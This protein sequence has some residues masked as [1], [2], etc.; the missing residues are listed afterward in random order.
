MMSAP[1]RRHA[2]AILAS[3]VVA[4][5]STAAAQEPPLTREEMREFLLEADIIKSR[6]IPI[7][8]TRPERL[9]LRLGGLTHD[10]GFNYADERKSV[11]TFADGTREVDFVDSYHYNIA[12]YELAGLLGLEDMM[13]VTVERAWRGRNGSL[14]WWLPT[15]MTEGE[16]IK[17]KVRPP[18]P[19]AWNRQMYKKRVFAQLVYD[20][21]PN[22]QNVIISPDWKLWMLDFTRAFRK[23]AALQH[24][25]DL[26][27]CQ[28]SLLQRLRELNRAD[29]ERVT[30]RHLTRFE[31]D[32][33]MKRRDL[34]V[35]HF[36]KLIA[37]K[38]EAA[39]LY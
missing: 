14:T 24:P 31:I 12:A 8:I 6:G 13:P 27:R 10:A 3:V 32:G 38:G 36:E 11:H 22:L 16:R 30:A 17:K 9:T 5:V 23:W 19:E 25:G 18:D 26:P 7:G 21:D 1:P 37:A 34:M 28:R 2:C 15:M 33:L 20:T 35:A 4:F 29:V 39:V